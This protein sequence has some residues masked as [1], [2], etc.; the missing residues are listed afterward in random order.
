MIVLNPR[1]TAS[2]LARRG[3]ATVAPAAGA[4]QIPVIDF[5]KFKSEA[6]LKQRQQ[7]AEEVVTAFKE[8]GFIYLR[9]HGI[10]PSGSRLPVRPLNP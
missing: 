2:V 7:T 10:S 9:N 1:A 6:G 3:L 4:F 8:S 5:A